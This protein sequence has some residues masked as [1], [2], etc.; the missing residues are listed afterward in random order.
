MR[1][2]KINEQEDSNLGVSWVLGLSYDELP[3]HMKPCFLHLA[4]FPE[5][6]EI[7]AKELCRLWMAE[8][9][10]ST[11]DAAYECFCELV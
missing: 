6:F 9:F 3:F 1:K 8:G 2:G 11:E 4:F 10:V 7:R 5:D